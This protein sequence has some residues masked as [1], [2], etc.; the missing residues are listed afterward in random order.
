MTQP[1]PATGAPRARRWPRAVL[2]LAGL[3]LAGAGMLPGLSP[4]S[5]HASTLNDGSDWG[6][7]GTLSS[8]SSVTVRWDNKNNPDADVVFRDGRQVI[9]HSGGKTYDDVAPVTKQ[10]YSDDFSDLSIQVSQTRGLT[11][12]AVSVAIAGARRGAAQAGMTSDDFFQVF[13]CWGGVTGS[14]Q[15]DPGAS[16]PDPATCQVGALGPDS[17]GSGHAEM[18]FVGG[19]PLAATG[20]WK[21]YHDAD[22]QT[23]DRFVPFTSIDGQLGDGDAGAAKNK[24]FGHATTN[25]LSAVSVGT[26]GTAVRQFE[27][28]TTLE[29]AGLG[30]GIQTSMPSTSNCWLVVVPRIDIT[31]GLRNTGPIAPTLWAQRL[32][33]R[34]NFSD[35]SVG[36]PSGQSRSLFGGSE[37]LMATSASWTPAVCAAKHVALGHTRLGDAVARNQFRTGASQAV[38]TSSSMAGTPS[39]ATPVAL[40]APVVAYQL[41]YTPACFDAIDP[42]TTDARAQQCGYENLAAAQEE[43]AKAGTQVTDLK[44]DARLLAKLFTQSYQDSIIQDFSMQLPD[45]GLRHRPRSLL[46]DPEFVRL[47]PGLSHLAAVKV[48]DID[49]GVVEALRSDASAEVWSWIL[50]DPDASAFLNGCPDPDGMIIN[51]FFSTRTYQGCSDHQGALASQAAADRAASVKA[52]TYVDQAATYPPE[53]SPFPL[54]TWQELR[55]PGQPPKTVVDRLPPVDHLIAVG[56]NVGIGHIPQ[57]DTWCE[58]DNSVYRPE[59]G[60]P[61]GKWSDSGT[62]QSPTAFGILGVTDAATAAQWRLPTAQLCDTAGKSCVGA[63]T[64]SLQKAASEF[65]T[66]S[67]GWFQPGATDLAGGAYP[68]TLPVYAAVN[69]TLPLD[70]RQAY[71]DALEYITTT[72]QTPGFDPGNLPPGYAPITPAMRAQAGAAIAQLRTAA[73]SSTPTPTKKAYYTTHPSASAGAS[74]PATGDTGASAPSVPAV[75]SAAVSTVASAPQLSADAPLVKVSATTEGGPSYLIPLGLGIALL[76]GFAGPLMRVWGRVRVTR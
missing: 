46:F 51:P 64:S 36:C 24:F 54:T 49:H 75:P 41:A 1:D 33:V 34:L 55:V 39:V 14:G 47:N 22:P 37:L 16:Q 19:D 45:W 25:E 62:R 66:D 2:A 69:P 4:G 6:P 65:T 28:Q 53:G 10:A 56:R 23:G 52:S 61:P 70:Q 26:K 42:V 12:Q 71:A 44:L 67:E 7:Q 76:A 11:N 50:A 13:Q 8:N 58:N 30:C 48:G 73:P 57:N 68:L 18:R 43:L 5:A 29:S 74:T 31:A 27:V 21:S 60:L 20:D 40:A 15:P 72:G 17:R 35:I 63:N 3:S 9:P 59:C 38:M 32:Q